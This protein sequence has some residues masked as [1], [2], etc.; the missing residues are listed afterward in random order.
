MIALMLALAVAPWSQP[1]SF[2][3][4]IGWQVGASGN[5][6]SVYVGHTKSAGE[7]LESAAWMARG[8]RYRDPATAD[9]PNKTLAR[10]PKDAVIVWAVIYNPVEPGEKSIRLDFSAARRYAC[11]EAARIPAEYEL[12][13]SG[14]GNAYSVIVR[15]YFGS[16]AN[17]RLRAEAQLAL[18][19]LRLPAPR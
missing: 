13:G 5:T 16:P 19:H 4:A 11:C 3:H 7:P 1:L 9:P 2:E 15:I 10:L 17:P 12:T 8:V 6:N 14:P 18:Q